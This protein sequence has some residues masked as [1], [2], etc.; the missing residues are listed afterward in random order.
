MSV[1]LLPVETR[2]DDGSQQNTEF[3]YFNQHAESKVSSV[4]TIHEKLTTVVKRQ[5]VD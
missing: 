5:L 2:H 3:S 4:P 1:H